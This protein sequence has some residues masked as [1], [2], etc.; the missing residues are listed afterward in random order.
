MNKETQ[1]LL[2]FSIVLNLVL[3]H[4]IFAQT[5]DT[6]PNGYNKFYFENGTISSEGTLKNGK[7]EGYWK[8][9]FP[10][11]VLKSEGNRL[12][13]ELDSIWKFYSEDGTLRE[14]IS[15]KQ[16]KR[17]GI[18]NSYSKEGF[19]E[20]SFPYEDDVKQGIAFT[21][22]TNG[23]VHSEIPFEK[24]AENGVAYE[25]NPQGDIVAIRVYKNGILTR[26]ESINRLNEEGE[27]EG[28]WKE[29]YD[30]R[31]V[32]SEGKYRSGERD[33]YWKEYTKKGELMETTKFDKGEMIKDAEEL[34]NL[35]VKEIYYQEGEEEG[36]LKFRGTFREG[37][38]HG[39][40]IWFTTTGEIDSTKV[41]KNDVLVA[42]G[43]MDRGG[44]KQ[45]EWK[46]YFYP[47]GGLKAEGSYKNGY[48]YGSW[49]YYFKNKEIEQRG[50][51]DE[52][53][54]PDGQWKWYYE[55]GKLEREE[56]YKNGRENGLSIEYSDSGTV[57]TQG[58]YIDGKEEGEW[59]YEIGDHREEGR[60]EYGA[61]TG[62]WKHTYL[63]TG[64]VKFE[65]EFYDDLPQEQHVWYYPSGQKMLEG[66]YVSG[67]KEGEWRRYYED[68]TIMITIDYQ[69]GK[70]VKVD[71]IKLKEEMKEVESE[72][73]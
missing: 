52:K 2:L 3:A 31:T 25:F 35:D 17:N 8:N 38:K 69:S 23:G 43:D 13:H 73:Q 64:R 47:E 24:G 29:F 7:P 67:V 1:L 10:S 48:K 70:E 41:Y 11:G 54:R 55:N 60:Y 61:K 37:K 9:Y 66:K 26:Q 58:E 28:V 56:V 44:L 50:K 62:V 65:G 12:N 72:G 27:K 15:Y 6:N 57:M 19:I 42:K 53:G 51:Y 20:A 22:Y 16:G 63:G 71:G 49:T 30:D 40:H 68:G 21:Y 39:T 46:E 59:F 4:E 18:T 5:K 34:S 14:E 45:G 32:K 36:K 33:G